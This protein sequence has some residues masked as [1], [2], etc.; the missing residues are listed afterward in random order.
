VPSGVQA[1]HAAASPANGGPAPVFAAG[2][3]GPALLAAGC[4]GGSKDPRRREP[5]NDKHVGVEHI[6]SGE[7]RFDGVG[8]GVGRA[9]VLRLYALARGAELPRPQQQ[10]HFAEP[11]IDQNSPQFQSARNACRSLTPTH[12]PAQVKQNVKVL[13]AL[14]KCMR[15]HGV[16]YFPDPNSEGSIVAQRGSGWDPSS[17]QFQ[18][19]QK[20]CASRN[21]ATG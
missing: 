7:W 20:A 1:P 19:A 16:L 3:A 6:V 21:P 8:L 17:R 10:R 14:A 4:G 12:S 11:G 9:S 15:K 18:A 2:L 13:L 5:R